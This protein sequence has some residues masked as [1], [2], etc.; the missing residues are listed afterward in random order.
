MRLVNYYWKLRYIVRKWLWDKASKHSRIDGKALMYHNVT[1]E[2]VN[3]NASCICKVDVFSQVLEQIREEGRHFVS[4]DELMNSIKNKQSE[5]FAVVTFDDVPDN[6]YTNAYPIL[7]AK[8]IPFVLFITTGFIGKEGYLTQEQIQELDKEPLCTIGAHTLTHPMLRRVKNS[9]EEM[10]ES[11][12]ILEEMLGHQVDYMAYPY[13]RQSS[14]SR[15]IM[16][17]AEEAGY[18][19]AFGTIQSLIS[20]KSSG[21][22]YY[23]PRVVENNIVI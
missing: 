1:D 10:T 15:R 16:R 23:L 6:F 7:K 12:K 3:T 21:N 18:L 22:L 14:V 2:D 5:K 17:E 13:G 20:D 9:K 19:C 4:V 8:N 11:K